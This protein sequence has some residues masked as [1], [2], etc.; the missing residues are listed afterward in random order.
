MPEHLSKYPDVALQVLKSGARAPFRKYSL[1]A[2]HK[3]FA[4]CRAGESAFK[5]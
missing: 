1:R 2:L 5:V 4:N 3:T